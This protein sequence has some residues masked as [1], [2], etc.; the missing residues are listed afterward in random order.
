M[1][2]SE[3][4]YFARRL[5]E[6]AELA[7][8]ARKQ[9]IAALEKTNPF[10][11]GEYQ[12]TKHRF[13]AV[14][15]FSRESGRFDLSARG[16]INTYALFAELFAGITSPRGRAGIILP[17]GIATEAATAPLFG[18]LVIGQRLA[19][20]LSFENEEM[21]FPGI[22]HSMKFCLLVLKQKTD[23]TPTKFV[24]FARDTAALVNPERSFSLSVNEIAQ[25]NP[26]TKTAPIFRSRADAELIAKLHSQVPILID[27]SRGP[28]GNPWNIEFQQ[29][30][31]NMTSDS[32]LFRTAAELLSAGF[33]PEG[34][35]WVTDPRSLHVDRYVPLYEAKMINFYDHRFGS[36]GDRGDTRGFRVLP[37]TTLQQYEDP[38]FE[39]TSY[40]FVPQ[41]EVKDRIPRDWKHEWLLAFKDITSAISERTTIFSVIPSVG[42]G[43]SAPLVFTDKGPH[44]TA[45]LLSCL[46]SLVVDYCARTKVGGLH[47]NYLYLKQFPVLAPSAY[48]PVDLAFI[49]SRVLELTYTSYSVGPLARDLSYDG[50]P[51]AWD[52]ARRAQVRA[53]LDAWYARAYGLTRDELR[54][55]LDPTD[56]KGADYPSE[57]FRVLK[58]N[59]IAKYGEYRTARLVLAA[60]DRMARDEVA[61]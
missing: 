59:E 1:Q 51:F 4:E 42:V 24:F 13:E 12:N 34:T 56:I 26:N 44:F 22:H 15:Q 18:S 47:L 45:A 30:L 33:V 9:A 10:L 58:K 31:F 49:V 50:P 43:N 55:I 6:I 61:I 11:F 57:T 28:T 40:Y 8:A 25:I 19:S 38:D 29:G 54:Y 32:G 52:E 2:L 7:G 21:I 46:N 36:F 14:N 39:P 60:W 41:Q 17:T 35:N 53:E 48:G 37:D 20:L 23:R 3:E 27:E 5:P 16:K